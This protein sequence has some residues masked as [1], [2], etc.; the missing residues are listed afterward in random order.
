[1]VQ[2]LAA[3]VRSACAMAFPDRQ[4]T[5]CGAKQGH[6]AQAKASQGFADSRLPC[7]TLHAAFE[8]ALPA[9]CWRAAT[10][11]RVF[12]GLFDLKDWQPWVSD[13]YE[14]IAVPE[15]QRA[16]SRRFAADRDRLALGYALH[17]LLLG[18]VLAC[19]AAD[20]PVRRDAAGCPRL[21]GELL[22]T[23]L[24]HTDDCLT[25]AVTETGPVGVDIESSKRAS[26]MPDIADRVCHPTD[27]AGVARLTG[28]ARNEALLALW[29]RKEA[30]LK[31]AGV[32]LQREMQ[33]FPAPDNAM[34]ALPG[35]GTSWVRMLD[36]GPK[37]VAAVASA[38]GIP[39]ESTWLCPVRAAAF[40]DTDK[41]P[42]R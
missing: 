22:S 34:L 38:P 8:S 5:P 41:R 18:K 15:R 25:L 3:L 13:A 14:L 24:S 26:V 31:A 40:D 37:W 42:D 20:V 33:T 19:D 16:E 29:V 35:G 17:R 11:V 9:R 1:M 30:F 28:L 21:S 2:A 12:V 36:A 7:M 6:M 4:G 10:A 32:G 23:S 39:V 27:A